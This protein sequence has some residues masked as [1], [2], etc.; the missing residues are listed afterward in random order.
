MTAQTVFP[1]GVGVLP[2]A[3]HTDATIA[4]PDI[5]SPPRKGSS[6]RAAGVELSSRTEMN[7]AVL[8]H[9][10][11]STGSQAVCCNTFS[12]KTLMT[13]VPTAMSSW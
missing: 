1:D 6:W 9:S 5:R 2:Q 12:T 4:K 13:T 11:I 8:S 7:T 3:R 10:R